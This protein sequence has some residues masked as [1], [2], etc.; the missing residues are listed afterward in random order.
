MTSFKKIALASTVAFG[1]VASAVSAADTHGVL[2]P[3]DAD[4]T[5]EGVVGPWSIYADHDRGTCLIE[6]IDPNGFVVQMGLTADHNY[7]YVG[8]FSKEFFKTD[9]GHVEK[10][11]ISV[12]GNVYTGEMA[13][14]KRNVADGYQGGYVVSA[15]PKFAVDI[16][17][18]YTLT[19]M[20]ENGEGVVISLD[21]THDA[22]EAAKKCNAKLAGG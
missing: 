22:I 5:K 21:G 13:E 8:V 1:L 15:D 2:S 3:G 11:A 7:G 10:M 16:Q 6:G 14:M 20:P 12:N 9:S 19:A 17:K 18:G 4:F